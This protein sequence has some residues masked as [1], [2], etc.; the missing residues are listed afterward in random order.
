ML[1]N[2]R[3]LLLLCLA[4]LLAACAGPRYA[5][6]ARN[7]PLKPGMGRI[8]IFPTTSTSCSFVSRAQLRVNNEVVGRVKPDVFYYVDRAPGSYV[9]T[10]KYWTGDGA[11]FALAA[12]ET[13]YVDYHF[14]TMGS[15][16][17]GKPSF[18]FVESS[19]E[20]ERLLLPMSYGG[21]SR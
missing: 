3:I 21:T 6:V 11:S 4:S 8:F 19:A 17:C 14:P 9:V 20:A 13:R 10:D 7:A 1:R 15:S 18:R 12:G 5:E 16:G 2:V